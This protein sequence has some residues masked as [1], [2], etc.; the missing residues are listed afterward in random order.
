[1]ALNI[2]LFFYVAS[3][4]RNCYGTTYK[5]APSSKEHKKNP[6]LVISARQF[7]YFQHAEF[8][9]DN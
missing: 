2:V 8:C 9:L 6:I 3:E 1:M 7:M 4:L 5:E